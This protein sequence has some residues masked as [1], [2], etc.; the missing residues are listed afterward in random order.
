MVII[1]LRSKPFQLGLTR[2][3]A[4]CYLRYML[5]Y[6]PCFDM[7]TAEQCTA[8]FIKPTAKGRHPEENPLD[9]PQQA[10]VACATGELVANPAMHHSVERE[11]LA[12]A[13]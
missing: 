8:W 5:M 4:T 2:S 3:S 6:A 9:G 7:P 11:A 10:H 12:Y 13:I 1:L